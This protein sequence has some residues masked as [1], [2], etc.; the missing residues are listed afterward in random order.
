MTTLRPGSRL[1]LLSTLGWLLALAAAAKP[2]VSEGLI[3]TRLILNPATDPATAIAITWRTDLPCAQ[4]LVQFVESTP[5][6]QFKES[7]VSVPARTENVILDTKATAFYHSASLT[8]LKPATRYV[9][10]VGSAEAWSEWNQFTTAGATTAPFTFVYLGDP[11]DDLKEHVTRIFRTADQLAPEA[12]FWLIAGDLT[13]EPEDN[14]TRDLFYAA[15]PAF[16][17]RLVFPVIGNHDLAFEY[18]ANGQI[19]LNKKGKKQRTLTAPATW[20]AQFTLPENGIP[21]Y[22]ELTWHVDY[23]GV[24]LIMI[25]SNDRLA[26]QARWLES[27]LANNPNR[28]TVVAFHHPIFSAGRERDD[29]ETRD[30]FLPLL[31]RYRVDLVLTGHDHAY[32]RTHPLRAGVPVPPGA[33]GTVFVVSSSGSKFYTVNTTGSGLMA[34]TAGNRQLF[35]KITICGDRLAY[36]SIAANGEVNDTFELVKK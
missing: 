17:N 36:A 29:R 26:E 23:Q 12:A 32:A 21:G 14:Q 35:Q 18:D 33:A 4:P 31:D 27:L 6:T 19:V 24:R 2:E 3:P 28:W 1:L 7:A 34:K 30:I 5:G 10:R 22:E 9:Y 13:S 16:R 8:G 11:Q 20:R 25:N 15:G